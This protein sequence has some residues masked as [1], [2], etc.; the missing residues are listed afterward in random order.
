[1]DTYT[2][3]V[4]GIEVNDHYLTIEQAQNLEQIYTSQGYDDIII[5]KKEQQR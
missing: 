2:V 4:G 1:M 5:A 3:W